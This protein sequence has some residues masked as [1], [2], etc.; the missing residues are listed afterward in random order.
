[1]NDG[2]S[3]ERFQQDFVQD[4]DLSGFLMG[5]VSVD[6]FRYRVVEEN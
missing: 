1:M 5:F 2:Q 6:A 3:L 4:D